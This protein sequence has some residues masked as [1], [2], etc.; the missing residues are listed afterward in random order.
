MW[1]SNQI[2]DVAGVEKEE[3]VKT[4]ELVDLMA[5]NNVGQY[6]ITEN[7]IEL[8]WGNH[9]D[10]A[11]IVPANMCCKD[12]KAIVLSQLQS[13]KAKG[14]RV[15][16]TERNMSGHDFYVIVVIEKWEPYYAK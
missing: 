10:G 1:S 12:M 14:W 7:G 9:V 2:F 3:L 4:L 15:M 5:S 8:L 11:N 13:L 16:C 6:I